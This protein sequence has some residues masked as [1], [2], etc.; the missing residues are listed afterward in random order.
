MKKTEIAMIVLIA[1]LSMFATF[2]IVRTIFGDSIKKEKTVPVVTE[3]RDV[4][5]PPSKLIFNEKAINPTVE[6]YIEDDV[7]SGAS[8]DARSLKTTENQ[9]TESNQAETNE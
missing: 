6:V 4:L 1:S 9:T 7:F 8:P 5:I 2:F 3:V